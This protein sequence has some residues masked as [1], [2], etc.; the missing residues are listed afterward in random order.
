M[1]IRDVAQWCA[2]MVALIAVTVCFGCSSP[3]Q[4]QSSTPSSQVTV[5]NT[6]SQPVPVAAQGTANVNI[7]NQAVT[8][9]D[10]SA[11]NSFYAAASCFWMKN[12]QCQVIPLLNVA[13]NQTAV[14]QSIS[15]LCQLDSGLQIVYYQLHNEQG[16]GGDLFLPPSPVTAPYNGGAATAF[17]QN[18]TTY[19]HGGKSGVAIV[20]NAVANGPEVTSNDSCTVYASGYLVPVP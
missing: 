8:T 4:A 9:V 19:F 12:T 16:S 20:F 2:V 7:T 6:A 17:N 1:K 18:V 11:Q 5:V 13:A 10:A 14:V 3:S 15:G